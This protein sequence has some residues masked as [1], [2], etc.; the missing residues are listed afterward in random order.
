MKKVL[1]ML[2]FLSIISTEIFAQQPIPEIKL[3]VNTTGAAKM[4]DVLNAIH[5]QDQISHIETML[6]N[7]LKL[8][9]YKICIERYKDTKPPITIDEYKKFVISLA[10]G[11]PETDD[12]YRLD[13]AVSLYLNA[14]KTP[15]KYYKLIGQFNSIPNSLYQDA[16]RRAY[17]WSLPINKFKKYNFYLLIDWS[18]GVYLYSTEK[19]E[20]IVFCLLRLY[21]SRLGFFDNNGN[22]KKEDV[23]LTLAHELNHALGSGH[24]EFR[25]YSKNSKER[26]ISDFIWPAIFEGIAIKCCQNAETV[27]SKKV[28]PNKYSAVTGNEP[29]WNFFINES[30]SIFKCADNILI[31]IVDNKYKTYKD[32][33]K[34]FMNHWFWSSGEY[35]PGKKFIQPRYYYLGAEMIGVIY[36]EYGKK[37]V[38][39]CR[40]N[41][42]LFVG[43][44][45]DALLKIKPKNYKKYLFDKKVVDYLNGLANKT[46]N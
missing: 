7:V 45:N 3:N 9:E 4:M 12:N 23:V 5:N 38:L 18:C 42:F 1:F 37:G 10:D 35:A 29:N 41:P 44:F 19:S 21:D 17:E 36:Q 39:E 31:N 46:G 15:Q 8:P 32:Y 13:G 26:M 28:Y 2:L 30:Q 14:I 11:Y 20:D 25:K 40:K 22:L 6:D 16:I 43:L 24:P 33:D 27:I 34:A